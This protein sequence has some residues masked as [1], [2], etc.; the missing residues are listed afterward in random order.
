MTPGLQIL[1]GSIMSIR[2]PQ[3]LFI[4]SI[5]TLLIVYSHAD[6]DTSPTFHS[7]ADPDPAS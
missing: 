4:L 3:R 5:W 7:Y 1:K 6:P 2:G